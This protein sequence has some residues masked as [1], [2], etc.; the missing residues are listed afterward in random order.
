MRLFTGLSIGPTV[1]ES[2]TRLTQEM[3]PIAPL[4]WSPTENFHI[5]TKFV[6]AWPEDRLSE[7]IAALHALPATQAFPV[8]VARLGFLPNP[9]RPRTLLAG[10]QAGPELFTL[11]QSIEDALVTI[12]CSREERKYTPH[13]TLA[14][15]KD[16]DISGLRERIASMTDLT[17]G[18]FEATHFHLYASKPGPPTSIYS[19]L[20]SFPLAAEA[21]A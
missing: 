3:K 15:I 8:T 5:T 18:S 11:V 20:E 9:H 1:L 2:L 4:K 7:M 16:E 12:G 10:V 6:G 19:I 21:S 13:V 17:F 14:R